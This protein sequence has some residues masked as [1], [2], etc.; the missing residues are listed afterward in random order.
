MEKHKKQRLTY[1]SNNKIE[2]FKNC[3]CVCVHARTF[4]FDTE[5]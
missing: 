5:R 2:Q 3:M 4:M 1:N